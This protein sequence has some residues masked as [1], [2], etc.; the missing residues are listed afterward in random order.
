MPTYFACVSVWEDTL[1]AK[2]RTD[3]TGPHPPTCR[4]RWCDVQFLSTG[5]G[6]QGEAREDRRD[7]IGGG[8]WW[9]WGNQ[10]RMSGKLSQS[11]PTW[12]SRDHFQD[13]QDQMT[14]NV[15]FALVWVLSCKEN[16]QSNF[17]KIHTR[18]NSH[19]PP[20]RAPPGN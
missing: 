4:G 9:S 14:L 6:N 13:L 2:S 15:F 16:T 8:G 17:C 19:T 11:A 18:M 7:S 10:V 20:R 12:A 5:Q 3:K 1:Y